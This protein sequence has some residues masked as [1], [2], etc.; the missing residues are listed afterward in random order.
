MWPLD[1]E[2]KAMPVPPVRLRRR[3]DF[4]AAGK[5][6]RVHLRNLTLQG[7]SRGE[8][9]GPRFGFTVTK[10]VGSAVERNRIRRRLKEAMRLAP[11]LAAQDDHDYVVVARREALSAQFVDLQREMQRALSRL[12]SVPHKPKPSAADAGGSKRKRDQA[13]S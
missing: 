7:N 2:A 6:K 11:G 5:G 4:V 12:H 13:K 10:K 1:P 9:G 8:A 3:A